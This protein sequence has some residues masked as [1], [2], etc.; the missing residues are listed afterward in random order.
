M[1]LTVVMNSRPE[2]VALQFLSQ[3]QYILNLAQSETI[4]KQIKNTCITTCQ[5]ELLITKSAF[6]TI[7]NSLRILVFFFSLGTNWHL[8]TDDLYRMQ[9]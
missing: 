3:K 4:V 8:P 9:K 7:F 1:V 2:E 6:T 5:R